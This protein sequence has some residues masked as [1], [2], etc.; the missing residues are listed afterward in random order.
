MHVEI[1]K[2]V[3]DRERERESP[4]KMEHFAVDVA[5]SPV[6]EMHRSLFHPLA[7]VRHRT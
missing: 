1:V 5:R 2:E 3:S 7:T 4:A 6:S